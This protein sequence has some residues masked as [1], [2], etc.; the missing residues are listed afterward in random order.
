MK[1]TL[2]QTRW[3]KRASSDI[4]SLP[5][6]T[7]LA[8]FSINGQRSSSRAA[9]VGELTDRT[10][11]RRK[12]VTHL[13]SVA[14]AA[15]ECD[16]FH[17][18][19]AWRPKAQSAW[20]DSHALQPCVH[21]RRRWKVDLSRT[22]Q[23]INLGKAVRC[24]NTGT[25]QYATPLGGE[26][27][28]TPEF[29][30]PG[31]EGKTVAM[32]DQ[33]FPCTWSCWVWNGH[34]SRTCSVSPFET[35]QYTRSSPRE[36]CCQRSLACTTY[37]VYW[38]PSQYKQKCCFSCSGFQAAIETVESVHHCRKVETSIASSWLTFA[39][40]EFQGGVTRIETPT[41]RLDSLTHLSV[42]IRQL[43][44]WYVAAPKIICNL[45]WSRRHL[46]E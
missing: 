20:F 31:C 8:C 26:K 25:R 37:L 11:T 10:H 43:C 32:R 22:P 41:G 46:I 44:I 42:H 28:Q 14:L 15:H 1:M 16:L 33:F 40:Y 7:A 23:S 17:H 13:N 19:A 39:P 18:R 36:S 21:G 45:I 9:R 12:L 27:G 5:F 4:S 35:P 6:Y 29:D 30:H 24:A 34:L 3:L 2:T 38:L